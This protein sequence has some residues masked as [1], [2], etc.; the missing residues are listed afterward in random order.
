MVSQ[1]LVVDNIK[2][3]SKSNVT[4]SIQR[5]ID[6]KGDTLCILKNCCINISHS[7]MFYNGVIIGDDTTIKAPKSIV[8]RN[9]SIKGT[10]ENDVV[11]SQWLE[12]H[13]GGL[14]NNAQFK[15]L[16]TLCNGK[17]MTHF[18]TQKGCY[19]FTATK[20]S[21]PIILPS[22]VY[23]HNNSTLKLKAC[24]Y[25]KYSLV[26]LNKVSNV[27]IDGGEFIGD[28]IE[29]KGTKGEWGHGI[30]CG[31]SSN[32]VLKNLSCKYFFGDGI[33]FIEGLDENNR[34][35]ILCQNIIV[36]NVKSSYNR[37]QGLSIEAAKD[38]TI[39][40][41]EF[42][43]TGVIKKIEPAAGIDIEPW[44]NNEKKI[45]N[46]LIENC[47]LSNNKGPDLMI[48]TP[49]HINNISF[50]N[51]IVKN[52]SLGFAYMHRIKGISIKNTEIRDVI[53]IDFSEYINVDSLT[54]I[55]RKSLKANG[56]NVIFE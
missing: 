49:K 55:N 4:Y 47:N 42:S 36:D 17:K 18:Y 39:L 21:A 11:H 7:G 19:Y 53:R 14:C 20:N 12:L 54:K 28:M 8:F 56:I 33:D 9:V 1:T 22:N 30:K 5:P 31:G 2:Q 32:V 15:N 40:N 50:L 23:W 43:Y 44:D 24:D 51:V 10:W 34:P 25:E 46:I 13:E 35:T 38:V 29:H 52:S 48:Y 26:L 3:F 16:M 45:D 41:S 6:L 27:T 37:R